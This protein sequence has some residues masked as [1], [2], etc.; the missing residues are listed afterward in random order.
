[1]FH[2]MVIFRQEGLVQVAQLEHFYGEIIN[3]YYLWYFHVGICVQAFKFFFTLEWILWN[4]R[5]CK[6]SMQLPDMHFK[7]LKINLKLCH[8][9]QLLYL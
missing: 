8:S 6:I 7:F 4:T 5:N 1:M 2:S 9:F 3:G